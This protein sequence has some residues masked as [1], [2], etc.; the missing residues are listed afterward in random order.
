MLYLKGN[1]VVSRVSHYR[2]RLVAAIGRLSYLDDR[3]VFEPERRLC[4]AWVR[5]GAEEERAE[6][7]RL[8]AEEA[9]KELSKKKKKL[10][11][12]MKAR[13]RARAAPRRPPVAQRHDAT[14][15]F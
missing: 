12:R 3:P 7:G 13:A 11:R 14:L 2:K 4:A 5:G 1:P 15:L 8:K 9:E 10:L 6:R